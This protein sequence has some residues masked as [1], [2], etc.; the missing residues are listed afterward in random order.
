MVVMDDISNG[1]ETLCDRPVSTI[2]KGLI[3]KKLTAIHEAGYVHGDL[4]DTNIMSRKSD[5][6]DFKFIDF[7]WAGR[8]N[9]TT[10]PPFV[11]REFWRP[12]GATD[13]LPILAEHDIEM[14]DHI[15]GLLP[16]ECL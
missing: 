7:D 11:N 9:E 8:V 5:A 1:Y 6:E 10:Y 12:Q 3:A 15:Q 14:L 4:R 2:V 13:F 16:A